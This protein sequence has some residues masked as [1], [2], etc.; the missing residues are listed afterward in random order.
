MD[1][2]GLT[3]TQTLK[4]PTVF[5]RSLNLLIP[6]W[7]SFFLHIFPWGR[8]AVSM[9]L[10][11]SQRYTSRRACILRNLSRCFLRSSL[12]HIAPL[13]DQ[14]SVVEWALGMALQQVHCRAIFEAQL[15]AVYMKTKQ[16]G[17]S[18]SIFSFTGGTLVM[19]VLWVCLCFN[20]S[21]RRFY[22]VSS[23]TRWPFFQFLLFPGTLMCACL[24]FPASLEAPGGQGSPYMSLFKCVFPLISPSWGIEK[25]GE[26]R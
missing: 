8:P 6:V 3:P 25:E 14:V 2:V 11:F 13:A 4:I 5:K 26:I 20:R 22:T 19:T 7:A 17:L 10:H 21:E 18:I 1:S 23:I 12:S 24:V 15:S 16:E 9:H